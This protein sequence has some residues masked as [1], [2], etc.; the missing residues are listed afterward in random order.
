MDLGMQIRI[1][2]SNGGPVELREGKRSESEK[3]I[4]FWIHGLWTRLK[5]NERLIFTHWGWG[6]QPA[7]TKP[8]K[9]LQ[10]TR[11]REKNVKIVV[12]DKQFDN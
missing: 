12:E 10:E 7:C 11:Q 5:P 2:R 9:N 6:L 8:E 3:S 4:M 1:R